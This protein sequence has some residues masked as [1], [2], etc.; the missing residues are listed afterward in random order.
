[1]DLTYLSVSMIK[2]LTFQFQ[3]Q[4]QA[5]KLSKK[6]GQTELSAIKQQ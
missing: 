3:P 2:F 4:I 1:M 6:G 5:R